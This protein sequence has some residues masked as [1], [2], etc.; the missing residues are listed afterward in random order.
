M[1]L[2]IIDYGAGNLFSIQNALERKGA[3]VKICRTPHE[4]GNVEALVIPGVG[5]FS[6]AARRIKR[7]SRIIKMYLESSIPILGICLGLQLVFECSEE[8]NG[9]GLEIIAGKVHRFPRTVKVPH[10]GWNQLLS[11]G[12]SP[13][14]TE[15]DEDS[16]FYFAHSYF[17]QPS[18]K[19]V[20]MAETEYGIMFPSVVQYGSFFG[21]QFH[22]EK[23]GSDGGKLLSCFLRI[24]EG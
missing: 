18:N 8:G 21:T 24:V 9:E 14:L 19:S 4:I 23:S 3:E 5:S 1:I 11:V 17:A 10:M 13:L 2:A 20:I 6:V 12:N 22:P 15:V 7:F 16:W